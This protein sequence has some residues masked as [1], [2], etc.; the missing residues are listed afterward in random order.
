MLADRPF[1]ERHRSKQLN[2]Q[3]FQLCWGADGGAACGI[4]GVDADRTGEEV[5][6]HPFGDD[7]VRVAGDALAFDKMRPGDDQLREG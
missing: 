6:R 4:G 2:A 5:D 7:G 1:S 3:P